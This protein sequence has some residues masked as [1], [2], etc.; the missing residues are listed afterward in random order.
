M[1]E[2]EGLDKI[3]E[4]EIKQ[5]K[6]NSLDKQSPG[7]KRSITTAAFLAFIFPV[8]LSFSTSY[9]PFIKNHV[10]VEI[11]TKS[12]EKHGEMLITNKSFPTISSMI[13]NFIYEQSYLVDYK[14]DAPEG[15]YADIS[16]IGKR[17]FPGI[18]K[19]NKDGS[20]P[21]RSSFKVDNLRGKSSI[22]INLEFYPSSDGF[23]IVEVLGDRTKLAKGIFGK[24]LNNWVY[25]ILLSL[26]GFFLV[27]LPYQYLKTL[28]VSNRL[29]KCI[30]FINKDLVNNQEKWKGQPL[31]KLFEHWKEL[32]CTDPNTPKELKDF[33]DFV[34]QNNMIM[35]KRKYAV[36]FAPLDLL[37]SPTFTKFAARKKNCLIIQLDKYSD[38][39]SNKY[40]NI[41]TFRNLPCQELL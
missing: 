34:R 35:E 8:L 1:E 11:N 33:L 31:F 13:L 37:G 39:Y 18:N 20:L 15:V 27:Y 7:L 38:E 25:T 28:L 12:G 9:C 16:L 26:V 5:F 21:F 22:K 36:W 40:S 29:E 24:F 17:V 10:D 2:K 41:V 14:Y 23:D 32:R 30:N 6:F 3:L 19:G 4:E